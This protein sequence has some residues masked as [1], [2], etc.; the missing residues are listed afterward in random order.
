M[1]ASFSCKRCLN[2]N[3][4]DLRLQADRTPLRRHHGPNVGLL[5]DSQR[6]SVKDPLGTLWP[7]LLEMPSFVSHD[8]TANDALVD[9]LKTSVWTFHGDSELTPERA[10]ERVASGEFATTASSET[11]WVFV[12]QQRVGF[13]RIFDL[14][15]PTPMFDIRLRTN[16]RGL[17]YGRD[18]VSWLTRRIFSQHPAI[19]RIEA[20]TRQ[21][22]A[23][24]R[25]VLRHCGYVKEAH[26]REAWEG[27]SGTYDAV[28]Y[29]IL[30][31]DWRSGRVTPPDWN[32]EP[33]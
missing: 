29:A 24:M 26:Y 21:D 7:R 18:A 31:Q 23:A 22:N 11:F 13:V 20:T 32:D 5:D 4:D 33:V 9:F 17:G 6:V 27:P 30:R 3:R 10:R 12:D 19:R 1:A 14:D 28:G 15:T 2:R 16:S 8:D 25:A